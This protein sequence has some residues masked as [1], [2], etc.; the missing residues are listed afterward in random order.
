MVPP[1]GTGSPA[2]R[3]RLLGS[4]AAVWASF[5]VVHGWLAVVGVVLLPMQAFWDV[6]LYRFWAAV[7]LDLGRWPVLDVPWVYPVGAVVP[8]VAPGLTG[9]RTT[10]GYA[11]AWCVL[12]TVLDALA[13][14]V[15]LRTSPAGRPAR[16]AVP[17]GVWWWLAFLLA[18]GPVA[19]GRLDAVVAP[20]CVLALVTA[21]R[22]PALAAVLLT[23]GAWIK[24]APGALL[25]PL[26]AVARRPVRTVVLPAALACAVVVG[27][28]AAGGGLARIAG[29]VTEQ[30]RRGLQVES[31]AATPWVLAGLV[32]DRVRIDLDPRLT[33]WEITGPGTSTA[34]AVLDVALPLA[35]AALAAILLR[36][37]AARAVRC[38]TTPDD[39]LLWG[40]L[41]ASAVLLVTNK[42]GSPQLVGWLAPPVVA[43]LTLVP[44]GP[45]RRR[46]T[47][48]GAGVL[49]IAALTQVVFP[50]GSDAVV[51]GDALLGSVLAVRNAGLVAVLVVA[52]A[53][54]RRLTRPAA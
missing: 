50:L 37:A 23:V 30:G 44:T 3:P 41:T 26:V 36:G 45:A 6:D 31:V 52:L 47:A 25:L 53:G 15:L 18:L 42:V 22:R 13:V 21:A 2:A 19:L 34:V 46:W 9:A 27:A 38:R 48:V 16:A 17:H 8:V 49:G 51:R 5:V 24:V 28:V 32:D 33:T 20:L 40:A 11:T 43:A 35:V 1:P 4:R 29:F 7:A 10:A 12:V 54:L 14:A 39:V